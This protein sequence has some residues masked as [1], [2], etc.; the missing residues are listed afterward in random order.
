MPV[1]PLRRAGRLHLMATDLS[2]NR[3]VL[4]Q[5]IQLAPVGETVRLLDGGPFMSVEGHLGHLVMCVWMD[6][7]GRVRRQAWSPNQLVL[8]RPPEL[9]WLRAL[10]RL[11]QRSRVVASTS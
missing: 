4:Q 2:W 6:E 11:T 5:S 3:T 7:T 1:M 8:C 10:A 9:T